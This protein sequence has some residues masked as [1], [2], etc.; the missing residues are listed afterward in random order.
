MK[1]MPLPQF[2]ADAD[3]E[4]EVS[5][6]AESKME[7]ENAPISRTSLPSISATIHSQIPQVPIAGFQA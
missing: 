1:I 2:E 3:P 4:Q 5:D 7:S 6:V